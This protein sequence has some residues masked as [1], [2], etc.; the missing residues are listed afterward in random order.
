MI[1]LRQSNVRQNAHEEPVRIVV[2]LTPWHINGYVKTFAARD[3]MA[4][5]V[6]CYIPDAEGRV[7]VRRFVGEQQG[8]KAMKRLLS[9]NHVR[10]HDVF[11]NASGTECC[12][13]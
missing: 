11:G 8:S 5:G 7:A 13:L 1:V 10:S 9:R 4:H 12:L 3:A 2:S 6:L